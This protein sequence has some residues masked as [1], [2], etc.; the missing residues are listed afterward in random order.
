MGVDFVHGGVTAIQG[1]TAGVP[2]GTFIAVD[3]VGTVLAGAGA[4]SV[5]QPA[6]TPL[7]ATAAA[8][9]QVQIPMAADPTRRYRL[10]SL[11]VSYAGGA[12]AGRISVTDGGTTILD[13]DIVATGPTSI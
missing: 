13:L 1:A 2:G 8:N 10:T 7:S 5:A 9:T 12:T 3:L 6:S 11:S 4:L